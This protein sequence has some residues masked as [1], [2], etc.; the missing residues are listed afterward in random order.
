MSRKFCVAGNW[1][2]LNGSKESITELA[3]ILKTGP[4]DPNVDVV[5]A[6]PAVYVSF[7]RSLLPSTIAVGGQNTYKAYSGAFTGETSPAQLKDVGG[8]WTILGNSERRRLFGETD[9]LVAEKVVCALA[10]R[11]KVIVCVGETSRERAAKQ[12]DAV[13]Q[14]QLKAIADKTEDWKNIVIAYEPLWAIET[15]KTVTPS[16]AQEVH[17]M[18][19]FWLGQNVSYPVAANIRVLYG[20]SVTAANCKAFAAKQDIDGFLV[21]GASLTPEFVDIVNAKVPARN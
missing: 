1:N 17:T 4:L 21:G 7:A 19:K 16:D 3:E 2:L 10:E 8:S 15:G 11:L 20:G 9:K 12:T 6:F 14:R 13:I 18:L 5:V